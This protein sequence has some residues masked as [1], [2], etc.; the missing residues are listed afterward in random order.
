MK[1]QLFLLLFLTFML[2]M[3]F[4]IYAVNLTESFDAT[5]FP[6]TDWTSPATSW[7]R[8]TTYPNTGTASARCGYSS[9]NW[10]LI[11]PR[12]TPVAGNNIL[13]FYVRD[14]SSSTSYDYTNEYLYVKVS[15]T[16]NATTSFVTTKLTKDYLEIT[17][18]YQ[19]F[20]VDLSEF[21][22]MN[23]YVA[24]H[25][26]ATGG[27]Y[28]YVDDV[29]GPPLYVANDPEPTNH[30]TDFITTAITSSAI[31]LTWTG[32]VGAQ[33]PAKYLV[34]GRKTG[35]GS[36][37]SVADATPVA[38]DLDWT[39]ATANAAKNVAFGTN[40]YT[41]NGLTVNTAY[42]FIIYPYTNDGANI[43]FLTDPIVPTVSTSTTDP[44]V[45]VFSWSHGF[46]TAWVGTPAAPP[47]WSQITV[48]GATPWQRSTSSPHLGT[49][50][51]L[52]Q[53][54]SA[55]GEH[56]L[57]TPPLS[58][59]TN[60]YRLKFW[61]KGSSSAGT[62]LKVQIATSNSP[63]SNFTTDL[64]YYIAGTNMP[65][66]WTEQTI[67]LADYEG[68]Q[69][70]A[71]RMIDA[72]GY[73]LF[74]DD[75]LVELIPGS[76][77]FSVNPTSKAFG[78]GNVGTTSAPQTF[79]VS[80]TGGGTLTINPAV[81]ITGA[82]WDQF[83]LTDTN[84]YPFDI[85][86]GTMSV[87]VTFK[88]T[89]EGSKQAY[90]TI[91][92][93]TTGKVTH[94]I[95]LTGTGYDP[96]KPL[97]YSQDFN[98][99]TSL[100]A[101]WTGTFSISSSSHGLTNNA[102]Y[103]N[104]WASATTANVVT[105][106]IG[107][108]TD[109]TRLDFDYR[110]VTYSSPNGGFTL[111]TGDKLEVQVST[112]NGANYE[113]IY[114]IDSSNHLTSSTFTT[115]SVYLTQAKLPA[116]GDI[117]KIKLLATWGAG[118][119]YLD[120]DNIYVHHISNVPVF[121]ILP[122][123]K[124]FGTIVVNTT[125]SQVFTISN[126]GAGTLG[127]VSVAL[128]GT[129]LS[130][131]TLIDDNDYT[132][133]LGDPIT[134]TVQYNPTEVGTHN[135]ALEITDDI[136]PVKGVNPPVAI[137]GTSTDAPNVGGGDEDSPAG[138]YYFA[139]NLSVTAPSKP[140]YSWITQT[141][142][143]VPITPNG[144]TLDDGYWGP[145]TIGFDFNYYGQTYDELYINTNGFI[146]FGTGSTDLSNDPIP[147]TGTPNN[148]IALFWDDLRYFDGTTHIYYGGSSSALV[149]TYKDI[150]HYSSTYNPSSN[151]VAQVILYAD[152]KIL[153]QYQDVVGSM[154]STHSATIGIE[155]SDGSKGIQYH[156][157][158]IGGPVGTGAKDGG[159]AIMFGN[160]PTTLPVE[161]S[162]FTATLTADMYVQI[163]WVAE[164]ETNH[165]GYNVLRNTDNDMD[166]AIQLN[167]GVISNGSANGTQVSYAFIDSEVDQG[168]SYYYWLQSMDLGGT[169]VFYGPLSVT[170][171]GQPGDPEVPLVPLVTRLMDAYPNPFNPS[172]NLRFDIKEAGKVTIDIYN[173]RGQK[174][175]RLEK[176]YNHP[177]SY[178]IT[179]DGKDA[180]GKELS[181]GVY[182]Y[183]MN[184]GKYTSSKKIVL[185]K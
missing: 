72:D 153:M 132:E 131:Y 127:I 16:N 47:D 119:Y 135:V 17:T 70:I 151:I 64:A 105:C 9:G 166:T 128:T 175:R 37:A 100:P 134:V 94:D 172:T 110:Y 39:G 177:G 160:D 42:D 159:V 99:S 155:N 125:A 58:F 106:P 136:G 3:V 115:C 180:Q 167:N 19:Q 21:N 152:G 95:S 83:E 27:N 40:T 49:N 84:G 176:T 59:G 61:L 12:L 18:T 78:T 144:G 68:V 44:T 185:T 162:S 114:T 112:D 14:H 113:T 148:I 173:T 76:P 52:A 182:I 102:L 81:T 34:M 36:Y 163:A 111:G 149:I 15:T 164:T 181:S 26:L 38:D 48:S 65:T 154:T 141:S 123:S 89:S 101:D 32:S 13:T 86:T 147:A 60:D 107:P 6:P 46:E 138:G 73:S 98:A 91:I 71:F 82:N 79:V 29:A 108:I 145:I 75:V 24:F 116:E 54:T 28:V 93:N 183:R 120:I 56:L 88:P 104:L 5:T 179:W 171:S 150:C 161:L 156:Y 51:A 8:S 169:S 20:S 124:D 11:T 7:I 87:S 168:E 146:S 122:A 85:T 170:I 165:L 92:D 43:N 158:G 23:I 50:C 139:N 66:A 31:T 80:N 121:Q 126:A 130:Q 22:D 10:W 45:T 55:G 35:V 74:I 53:W 133:Y 30:V 109:N 77:I 2:G 97:P 96:T 63:A 117:V 1:K 118:D 103:K 140:T 129:G 178:Q 184:S 57:I 33:L 143:E 142:N 41:F 69:F 137:T 62:D 4:E 25:R 67:S 157:N 90:L 174:L